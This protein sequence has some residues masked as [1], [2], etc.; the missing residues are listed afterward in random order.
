MYV[1]GVAGDIHVAVNLDDVVAGA[2][3]LRTKVENGGDD[4]SR[5]AT[6][7]LSVAVPFPW[8]STSIERETGED[9]PTLIGGSGRGE[10]GT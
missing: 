3:G 4:C 10:M 9:M 7:A 1:P 8:L 5:K 2:R 6:I